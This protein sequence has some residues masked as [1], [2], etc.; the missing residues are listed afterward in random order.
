VWYS[1]RECITAKP[2]A[3]LAE[4]REE[5]PPPAEEA[6][7]AEAEAPPAA[8]RQQEAVSV[9]GVVEVGSSGLVESSVGSPPVRSADLEEHAANVGTVLQAGVDAGLGRGGLTALPLAPA[10]IY[11][12]ENGASPLAENSKAELDS[13]GA[14]LANPICTNRLKLCIWKHLRARVKTAEETKAAARAEIERR[15]ELFNY[16][17]KDAIEYARREAEL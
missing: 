10:Y 11:N 8:E 12:I 1:I 7:P 16:C 4:E 9:V 13:A 5:E 2:P 15:G 6:E 3:V 14:C 17:L